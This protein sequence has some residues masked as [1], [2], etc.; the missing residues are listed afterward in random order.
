MCMPMATVIGFSKRPPRLE[1]PAAHAATWQLS[2][3]STAFLCHRNPRALLRRKEE[4]NLYLLLCESVGV[5]RTRYEAGTAC[6]A[7]E[8]PRWAYL[9]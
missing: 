6:L 1:L 2:D 5:L 8:R 4:Q 7:P 9:R 3:D